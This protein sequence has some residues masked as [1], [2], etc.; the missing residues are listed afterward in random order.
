M[1]DQAQNLRRKLSKAN[2]H[3]HLAKTISFISGKGGV[4][5]SNIALNFSLSLQE[6]QKKVLLID[7]DIGMGNIEILLGMP[8]KKSIADMFASYLSMTE[9]IQ[10]GPYGLDVMSG[11]FGLTSVFRLDTGKKEHF[12]KEYEALMEKYDFIIFD[13]GAGVTEDS[14]FFILA[15][16]ECIVTTTPEPTSITDGYGMIKHVVS[17]EPDMP[18]HV[19]MNR[20]LSRTSGLQALQRFQQVIRNFLNKEVSLIGNVPND[21]LVQ[22]AVIKQVPFTLMNKNASVSRAVAD[23]A[24]NYLLNKTISDEKSSVSFIQKLKRL[25]GKRLF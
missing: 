10:R 5:K 16:D 25:V 22:E 18:I 19:V 11:G 17:K 3:Q 6:R 13:M 20:S 9:I 2:N 7:F 8:A 21:K 23:M 4:G 14:L 15:S 12:Y 24:E 1:N